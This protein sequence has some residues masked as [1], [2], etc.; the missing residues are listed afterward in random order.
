MLVPSRYFK[1]DSAAEI[2][3]RDKLVKGYMK[4]KLDTTTGPPLDDD[5]DPH[6]SA[7][8]MTQAQVGSIL[9]GHETIRVPELSL[10]GGR[11]TRG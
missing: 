9:Y 10:D 5:E 6:A 2:E 1:Q 8:E 7:G 4:L 11:G 3:V